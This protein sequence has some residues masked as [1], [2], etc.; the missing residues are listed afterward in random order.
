LKNHYA[1]A[2]TKSDLDEKKVPAHPIIHF[3]R[4]VQGKGAEKS[5]LVQAVADERRDA[6]VH[7]NEETRLVVL[8]QQFDLPFIKLFAVEGAK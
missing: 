6:L 8:D 3:S 4:R 7:L 2:H 5:S 1:R